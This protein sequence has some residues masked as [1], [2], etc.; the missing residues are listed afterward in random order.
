MVIAVRVIASRDCTEIKNEL[1]KFSRNCLGM[2]NQELSTQFY[3]HSTLV[4]FLFWIFN[5]SIKFAVKFELKQIQLS[6][7]YE[8]S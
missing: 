3:A 8:Y 1:N 2:M 6:F 7:I 4:V 5:A